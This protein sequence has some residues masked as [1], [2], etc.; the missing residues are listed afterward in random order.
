MSKSQLLAKDDLKTS[1]AEK[2][3]VETDDLTEYLF[4]LHN[5]GKIKDAK[6]LKKN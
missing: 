5:V 2:P 1:K 3:F 4:A 6:K